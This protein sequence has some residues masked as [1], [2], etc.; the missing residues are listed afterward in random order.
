[1]KHISKL[2]SQQLLPPICHSETYI[3]SLICSKPS[4]QF[5]I[6]KNQT[7]AHLPPQDFTASMKSGRG[8][9]TLG[10]P[11]PWP[12]ANAPVWLNLGKSAKQ[13]CFKE[14]VCWLKYGFDTVVNLHWGVKLISCPQPDLDLQLQHRVQACGGGNYSS[15]GQLWGHCRRR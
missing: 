10:N 3:K 1:M 6:G 9:K 5:S 13:V 15:M 14:A 12:Y 7:A 8:N 11:C 4:I 2:I